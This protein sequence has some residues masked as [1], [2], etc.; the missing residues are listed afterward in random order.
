MIDTTRLHLLPRVELGGR[1]TIPMG[2]FLWLHEEMHRLY[3]DDTWQDGTLDDQEDFLA[4]MQSQHNSV[5]LLH[6]D[7]DP[8]SLMWFNRHGRTSAWGHFFW[9]ETPLGFNEKIAASRWSMRRI[10]E[11][12]DYPVLVGRTPADNRRGI[13][14]MRRAGFRPAGEIPDMLYSRALGRPVAAK[15]FYI[16]RKDLG[17]ENL[18]T[19]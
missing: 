15:L 5:F 3:R 7:G 11:V 18:Q 10:F 4:I 19:G 8:V 1:A 13:L 6:Y 9:L 12:L 16:Q 17:Y 14:F 2:T